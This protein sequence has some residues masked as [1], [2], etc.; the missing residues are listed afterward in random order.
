VH[1]LP[2]KLLQDV[3]PT[4]TRVPPRHGSHHDALQLAPAFSHSYQTTQSTLKAELPR[5][6][7]AKPAWSRSSRKGSYCR[8]VPC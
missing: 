6:P 3:G 4:T 7:T 8:V 5:E 1:W 2:S